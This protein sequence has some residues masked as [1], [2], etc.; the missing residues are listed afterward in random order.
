MNR[1]A[2]V[3]DAV[4]RAYDRRAGWFDAFVRGASLGRDPVYRE[5]A[6]RALRLAPGARVLDLG[7]G[8]GLNLPWLAP[9]V[10]PA[11]RVLVADLS[12]AMLEA[13][14]RRARAAGWANAAFLQADGGRFRLAPASLDAALSTYALT[15][16]PRWP[17][18]LDALVAALRPGGR[19][20]ILDD[21]LPPGW[22]VG[23]GF[24][25]E[26]MRRD[27]WRDRAR[28]IAG[29]LGRGCR[30]VSVRNVHAGLIYQITAVRSPASRPR[31]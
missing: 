11:G 3:L 23:P 9:A 16:I 2:A 20:A 25:L 13:A 5:A 15:T 27:G 29:L 8:T 19:I 24:M 30:D 14:R 6:C 21:R 10:G 12:R 31:G 18:A 28:D 1:D 26:A 7:G 4:R 17:A 22:F